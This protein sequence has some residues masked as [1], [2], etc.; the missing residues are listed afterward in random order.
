[1]SV[2]DRTPVLFDAAV[3]EQDRPVIAALLDDCAGALDGDH[4]AV[5]PL[6]G[7]ANNR[8][9]FVECGSR[10]LVVRIANLNADRLAV[11]RT[12]A[13]QAQRDAAAAGVGPQLLAVRLPEGHGVSEFLDGVT[14]RE[15]SLREPEVVAAIGRTLSRLHATPT[16]ARRFS[17][18]ADIRGWVDLAR[19]D[20]TPLP[21]DLP[22][23]VELCDQIEQAL[24]A[25]ELPLVFCHNDTVPQNFLYDAPQGVARLV[26]WDYAGRGWGSFELA[27]LCATA[28]LDDDLRE[29]LLSA[30]SGGASAA[31]RATLDLLALVAAVREVSWALMAA[32]MLEGTTTLL[33][34]WSYQEH[35]D[36][37]LAR[38]RAIIARGDLSHTLAD[39][40]SERGRAW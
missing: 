14:L 39:A 7:G 24:V 37:N 31:Q 18:F 33:D 2:H 38:A 20:G 36:A 9:Y 3:V 8:N 11:D 12:S 28:D 13:A 25:A 16:T 27:S 22:E 29:V 17:P 4:A 21:P 23:L 35:R 32:P 34:G 19:A 15:H 40:A 26:D 30:Y 1:M 10:R 5:R 6:I